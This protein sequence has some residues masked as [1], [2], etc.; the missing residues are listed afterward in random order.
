MSERYVVIVG[1][2]GRDLLRRTSALVAPERDR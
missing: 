2:V 1:N